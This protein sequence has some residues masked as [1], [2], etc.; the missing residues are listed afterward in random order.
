MSC[1]WMDGWM[2]EWMNGWMDGWMDEWMNG[3]RKENMLYRYT[4]KRIRGQLQNILLLTMCSH[5]RG[6]QIAELNSLNLLCYQ[7]F[8]NSKRKQWYIWF[9]CMHAFIQLIYWRDVC[10]F[11]L[12]RYL[13]DE[14]LRDD[15]GINNGIH[16]LKVLEASKSKSVSQSWLSL[17]H[18]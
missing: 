5:T 6:P 2:N 3:D 13:N 12:L 16:R 1:Q 10:M 4:N 11:R 17:S 9:L 8:R 14:H 15:C 7:L 18:G